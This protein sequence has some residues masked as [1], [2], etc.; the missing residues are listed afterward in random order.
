MGLFFITVGYLPEEYLRECL[1]SMGDRWTEDM[2][3]ELFHGAPIKD[4]RFDYNE[5]TRTLKHGSR[6]K[7]DDDIPDIQPDT[8]KTPPEV[9]PKPSKA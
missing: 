8:Q 3:D 2:V 6:D 5:F 1:T 9:P 7:K 4:G